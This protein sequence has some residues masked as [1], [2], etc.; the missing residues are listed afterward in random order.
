M[1]RSRALCLNQRKGKVGII[2]ADEARENVKEAILNASKKPCIAKELKRIASASKR[3]L[4]SIECDPLS[5]YTANILR[6]LG[7]D[8]EWVN[9]Y[10]SRAIVSWKPKEPTND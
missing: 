2:T 7:H 10:S 3:G 1:N 4:S 9:T 6:E 5:A 8:V